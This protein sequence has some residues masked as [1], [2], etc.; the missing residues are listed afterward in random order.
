MSNNLFKNISIKPRCLVLIGPPASG[1]STYRA[2]IVETL[3]QPVIISGDDLIEEQARAL[4]K[5]YSEVWPGHDTNN[6]VL[7]ARFEDAIARRVDIIID[8]TNLSIKARR[9]YLSGLPK[10]YHR[11]GVV[12]EYIPEALFERIERRGAE[13]GKTI[14]RKSIEEMLARYQPPAEGEFHTVERVNS[15]RPLVGL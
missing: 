6:A 14:P 13:T 11:V 1:K 10:F 2:R 12:F 9:K 3:N 5:T 15:F 4:G 7:R 8:M